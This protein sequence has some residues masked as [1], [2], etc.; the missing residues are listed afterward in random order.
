MAP[1]D[2]SLWASGEPKEGNCVMISGQK[3]LATNDC[4]KQLWGLC[5]KVRRVC[6]DRQAHSVIGYL[7]YYT[8]F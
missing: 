4:G 7:C 3:G 6:L 1:V 5:E 2:N 8:F